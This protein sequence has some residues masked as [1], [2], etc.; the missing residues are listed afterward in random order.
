ME[1]ETLGYIMMISVA[2]LWG[3]GYTAV[4]ILLQVMDPFTLGAVR[5]AISSI[6]FV[7][8]IIIL[9]KSI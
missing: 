1:R 6:F 4:K 3:V 9:W 2:F 8:I 5:F 7:P